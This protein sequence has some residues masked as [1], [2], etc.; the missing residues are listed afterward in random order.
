MIL[1]QKD[2]TFVVRSGPLKKGKE[3]GSELKVRVDGDLERLKVTCRRKDG[4]GK[5]SPV[6][7]I[8][9]NKRVPF[10]LI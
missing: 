8:H 7:R 10:V 6:F 2:T 9:R 4:W 5:R 1:M 3:L